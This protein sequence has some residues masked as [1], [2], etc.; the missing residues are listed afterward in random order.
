MDNIFFCKLA[1]VA[2]H[3]TLIADGRGGGLA[4]VGL[5]GVAGFLHVG[6]ESTNQPA[7][8]VIEGGAK[9]RGLAGE[10]KLS[11]VLGNGETVWIR[12]T[13][14]GLTFERLHGIAGLSIMPLLEGAEI[15]GRWVFDID[16]EGERERMAGG[17]DFSGARVR[18]S[19]R[20]GSM[21]G[22]TL[23]SPFD[24]SLALDPDGAE[25]VVEMVRGGGRFSAGLIRG[26]QGL[27]IVQGSEGGVITP[28]SAGSVS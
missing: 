25:A 8:Y 3:C 18:L 15:L 2:P 16:E 10:G 13:G 23:A 11:I 1:A 17:L 14:Q 6:T 5:C 7:V 9:W 28:S 12:G 22:V 20:G 4:V 19:S 26:S 24:I 27:I 21:E